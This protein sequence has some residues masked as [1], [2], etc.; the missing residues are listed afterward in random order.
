MCND[1]KVLFIKHSISKYLLPYEQYRI[2][3]INKS[4]YEYIYNKSIYN[5]IHFIRNALY[6]N[7]YYKTH[8]INFNKIFKSMNIN[9]LMQV[10]YNIIYLH[11]INEYICKKKR[12]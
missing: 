11:K 12:Q 2:S 7:K 1:H 6:W 3:S 10:K 9:E 4:I 8:Q 5:H